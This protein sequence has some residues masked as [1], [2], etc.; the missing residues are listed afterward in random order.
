MDRWLLG[1]LYA[2]GGVHGQTEMEIWC[3]T[4]RLLNTM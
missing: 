3:I 4:V 1:V 2:V